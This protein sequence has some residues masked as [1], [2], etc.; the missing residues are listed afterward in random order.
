LVE[1]TSKKVVFSFAFITHTIT[2]YKSTLTK[3]F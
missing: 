2:L 3:H 1:L